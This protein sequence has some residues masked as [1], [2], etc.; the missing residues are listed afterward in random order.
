MEGPGE[1]SLRSQGS[2]SSKGRILHLH[3]RKLARRA[4][5]LLFYWTD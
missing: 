1:G 4:L 2:F 3:T 5:E